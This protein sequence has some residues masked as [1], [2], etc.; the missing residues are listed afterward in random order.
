KNGVYTNG[1][2]K[3]NG[4]DPETFQFLGGNYSKDAYRAY[5]EAM[6]I[7]SADAASFTFIGGK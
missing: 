2:E 5:W 6:P 3:I 7:E 1:G 4:A